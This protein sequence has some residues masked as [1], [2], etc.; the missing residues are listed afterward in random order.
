MNR[1]TALACALLWTAALP[2]AGHAAKPLDEGRLDP[3]WFGVPNLELRA[4]EE[5]DY[6]WVRPGFAL[7]GHKL[8]F[9]PWSEPVFLGEEAE[10]RDA[11]DR[12]LARQ[13]NADMP[14]IFATGFANA[15]GSRLGVVEQGEDVRV[16]GRIVDCS[17]GSAAAKFWVGMGA[18]AG[19]VAFDLKFVDAA[20]GEVLA[21]LHHRS[22]SGTNWSTTDSKLVGWVDDMTAAV[23]K[24]G[25]ERIYAKGRRPRD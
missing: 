25:F 15:F 13:M 19:S 17:T 24:Q 22:V 7:E 16:E 23:A 11:K 10:D 12:H 6:L 8:R 18:G 3:S 5:I 14:E 2:A 20:T 4:T 9:A 21:A 1:M